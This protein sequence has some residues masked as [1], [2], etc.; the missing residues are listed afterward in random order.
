MAGRMQSQLRRLWQAEPALTATGLLMLGLLPAFAAGLVL[1]SRVVTGAPVWLKPAKFAAS[2]GIYTLTLAWTFQWLR[3]WRLRRVVGWG[4][5][6]MLML[7]IAVIG[8]QAAR[9]TSSH[10]NVGTPLDAALFATMGLAIV[11]QT[12]LGAAVALALWRARPADLVMGRALA[13]GLTITVI[14]ASLGGLMTQ[15]TAVQRE[16]LARTGR[17]AVSGAHTVGAQDGGAGLPGTGWSVRHGDL[18]VPHF[19]GLHA[20]QAVPLMAFLIARRGWPRAVQLRL[21]TLAGASYTG[22]LG[23]LTW[24]ALRGQSILSPDALTLTAFAVLVAIATFAA[25]VMLLGSPWPQPR[26]VRTARRMGSLSRLRSTGWQL[27]SPRRPH[28]WHSAPAGRPLSGVDL[29]LRPGGVAALHG[30]PRPARPQLARRG[31]GRPSVNRMSCQLLGN[32]EGLP[33]SGRDG[34]GNP[35]GVAWSGR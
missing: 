17:M 34:G 32:S 10:F 1:D 19:V 3:D 13:I 23:I 22:F 28:A 12:F 21:I 4:T 9:G 25:V 30:S 33:H 27:G 31:Y 35:L 29:S 14:G 5:A 24:Q 2:I 20:F 26:G 11:A 18:R 15:P 6:A 8:G 16:A 7:E